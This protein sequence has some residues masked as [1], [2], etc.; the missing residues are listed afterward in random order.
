MAFRLICSV[1]ET[2]ELCPNPP[3]IRRSG[4]GC[5]LRLRFSRTLRRIRTLPEADAPWCPTCGAKT[6]RREKGQRLLTAP[7]EE[8][9]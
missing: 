8:E 9:W 7:G 1:G 6:A 3:L 2:G 4:C 5:A